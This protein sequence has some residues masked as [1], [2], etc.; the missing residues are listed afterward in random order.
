MEKE[1]APRDTSQESWLPGCS[2]ELWL[3][4]CSPT[5][6]A[7]N[8]DNVSHLSRARSKSILS[9]DKLTLSPQVSTA[10]DQGEP[11]GSTTCPHHGIWDTSH[12]PLSGS[13]NRSSFPRSQ[14]LEVLT[15]S[16]P[17]ETRS[18]LKG[19][20]VHLGGAGLREPRVQEPVSLANDSPD[21]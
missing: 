19:D 9:E 13:Q 8:S 12:C 6:E 1:A 5:Q 17:Q 10:T 18:V 20:S 3:P 2:L 4:G 21:P 7:N 14:L 16:R 15:P 11:E